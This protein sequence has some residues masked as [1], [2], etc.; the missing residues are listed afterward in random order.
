VTRRLTPEIENHILA[1]IRAGSF[2]HVA[3]QSAGFSEREFAEWMREGRRQ[4]RGRFRKF[5]LKVGEAQAFARVR[6]EIEVREKDVKFW[7]RYG[8]GK[9]RPGSAGWGPAD[10]K[11]PGKRR[12]SQRSLLELLPLLAEA[13]DALMPWPEARRA[14]LQIID[15]Q[16]PPDAN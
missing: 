3:A 16:S 10:K 5:W 1:R 12:D 7:L 6:A 13:A 4:R 9:E 14:V 11:R 8:P 15:R 2:P